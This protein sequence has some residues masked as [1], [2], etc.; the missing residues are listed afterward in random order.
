MN[1]S[2]F[3][4]VLTN[5]ALLSQLTTSDLELV[6]KE[7][8]WFSLAQVLLA[9]SYSRAGDVRSTQ[10]LAMAATQH[11]NRLWIHDF[12]RGKEVEEIVPFEEPNLTTT[13]VHKQQQLLYRLK[14]SQPI[15][16]RSL[17]LKPKILLLRS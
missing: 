14:R 13:K 7:Y 8:P 2:N 10:Q 9:K 5:P 15:M 17:K 6:V 16:S 11:A 1:K 12:I 4:Q 3:N